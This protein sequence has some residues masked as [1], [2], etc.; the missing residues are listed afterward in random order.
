MELI[1]KALMYHGGKSWKTG[2]LWFGKLVKDGGF[3]G[4]DAVVGYVGPGRQGTSK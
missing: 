4:V 3:G 1:Q 2:Q